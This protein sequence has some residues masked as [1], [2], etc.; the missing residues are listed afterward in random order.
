MLEITRL[1]VSW[2][3]SNTV[4]I[5]LS[6]IIGRLLVECKAPE[7]TKNH[8]AF[9]AS[10]FNM[11]RRNFLDAFPVFGEIP[12]DVRVCIPS[13]PQA[14]LLLSFGKVLE[15]FVDFVAFADIFIW[16]STGDID[17]KAHSGRQLESALL[18]CY[19]RFVFVSRETPHT[20][21]VIPKPF[22]TRCI[23]PGT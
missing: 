6:E 15:L 21:L 12:A 3:L 10:K 17:A 22:F 16:F 20:L 4:S 13:G 14:H 7:Q 23:L 9:I 19:M 18:S 2:R 8:L 1:Y 11:I 5:T